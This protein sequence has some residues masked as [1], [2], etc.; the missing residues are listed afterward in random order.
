MNDLKQFKHGEEGTHS[1]CNTRFD[2]EGGEAKCC[3]CIPHE[4]CEYEGCEL[5]NNLERLSKNVWIKKESNES[6][7]GVS[8]WKEYGKKYGY[9]K[10]FNQKILDR[11]EVEEQKLLNA[12]HGGDSWRRLI[13]QSFE[14]IKEVIKEL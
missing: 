4:G 13:I 6:I 10:Y 7:M 2:K 12:G 5:V 9:D 3:F 11:V 8:Q 1:C 14:N